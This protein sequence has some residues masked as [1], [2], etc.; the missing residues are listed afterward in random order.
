MTPPAR[1][2]RILLQETPPADGKHLRLC[3]N[4]VTKQID[5]GQ[6]LKI[7][8]PMLSTRCAISL[9]GKLALG[10]VFPKGGKAQG[11]DVHPKRAEQFHVSPTLDVFAHSAALIESKRQFEMSGV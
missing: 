1:R 5:L 11:R 7:T 6:G 8:F 10:I 2:R 3:P 9:I 4:M